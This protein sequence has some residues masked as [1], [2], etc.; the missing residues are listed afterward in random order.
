MSVYFYFH[1][2]ELLYIGSCKDMEERIKSHKKNLKYKLYK[3]PFY[4]YLEENGL[5][6]D[7]L[8]LEEVKTEITDKNQLRL[9]EGKCQ[10]LYTPKC[11]IRVERRT[12]KEW[13]EDNKDYI[14]IQTKGY[15]DNNKDAISV[16][17]KVHYQKN[18]IEIQKRHKNYRDNEDKDIVNERARRF[19]AKHLDRLRE[20]QKIKAREY[21][22]KKKL[23]KLAVVQE[24]AN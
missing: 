20:Y 10:R 19:R 24:Q 12:K 7:E 18:K 5:T 21:R 17:S 15:R 11:N 22:A 14:N 16:R 1:K 9:L 2:E 13:L 23:A 4:R 8:E 3:I 6:I